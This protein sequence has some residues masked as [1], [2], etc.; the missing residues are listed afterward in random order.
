MTSPEGQKHYGY[1]RVLE[2]DPTTLLEV[3]DGFGDEQ[4][5]PD[6]DMPVGR[7]RVE[8][9]EHEGGTRVTSVSTHASREDLEKLVQMGMEE[10]LRAAAGQIR[11]EEHTS[12]LQSRGH[13]VGRLRLEKKKQQ[14]LQ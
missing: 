13:L 14:R 7:M 6:D 9:S 3:E 1:W 2:A 12:E 5:N 10:G 4:G 8:F 11:S